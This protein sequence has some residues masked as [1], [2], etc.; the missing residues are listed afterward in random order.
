MTTLPLLYH[1]FSRKSSDNIDASLGV[2]EGILSDGLVLSEEEVEIDW[3]DPEGGPNKLVIKQHRLCLTYI[4][5]SSNLAEHCELFGKIGIGFN[6]ETIKGIGGFPVFYLP[7]PTKQGEFVSS[8]QPGVSLLYR[9][10]ECQG[11]LDKIRKQPP[12]VRNELYRDVVDIEELEG[13]IRFLGNLIYFTDYAD[14]N[15]TESFRYY[16]QREWRIIAGV[17]SN[18]TCIGNIDGKSGYIL[19]SYHHMHIRDHIQDV[20]VLG[21]HDDRIKINRLL[22]QYSMSPRAKI[23]H[24]DEV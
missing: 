11:V 20:V 16:K 17:E 19:S 14:R 8:S 12:N 13:A 5:K 24:S 6:I 4:D 1:C 3:N 23:L 9:L 15:S 21:C 7:T 22:E 10:S 18:T 2:L